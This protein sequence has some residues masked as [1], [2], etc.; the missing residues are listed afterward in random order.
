MLHAKY[1]KPRIFPWNND[2]D[3]EQID[4]AQDIGGDLTLNR[5]KVFEIGRDGLLGYRKQT[6]SFT[7]TMRQFE[8]GSMAFYYAL[9]NKELPGSGEDHYIDLN[10]LKET[11]CDIAAFL[12]DDND[13]FRGTI[14]F[15]KL[16]VNGFSLN[17][18]DPDAIIERNFN[19][20]GEDYRMLDEN[21]FSFEKATVGAPGDGTV[22]LDPIAVEYA[23]G[24]YI[25]RV[26][27]VRSGAVTELVED[28]GAGDNTW[29][30]NPATHVVT[31]KTCLASD[32]LKV[33]Y[34]SAT[35]YTTT[36]TNNNSDPELLL[37]EYAEI[38]LKVGVGTRIYRLQTIGLDVSFERADYKEIGNSEVVQTGVK[39][40]TVTISLNRFSENFSLEDILASD[41][42]YP[43]INPRNFAENIQIMIKIF[44]EKEHATFKI[45]YLMN[46]VSPTT[47]GTSQ[48]VE[49]YNQRSNALECDNLKISDEESE[50]VFA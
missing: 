17:I 21:Y 10:D 42:A 1:V 37:S 16:R 15:P 25:F 43:Y 50:I 38:Y 23:S 19:L 29:S 6:P 44:N 9:A 22:T 3:P 47:L 36:W 30:Y 46:N 4:R 31:V 20:I 45:G 18:A 48:T 26:L 11:K 24:A 5:E 35:A 7:Y 33:Y 40:K 39:N 41:T 12:T 27:R 13:I 34:E 8:Y 2:R 14:W 28:I 32:I 49:D